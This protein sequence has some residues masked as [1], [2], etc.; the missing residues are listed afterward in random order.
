[1]ILFEERSDIELNLKKK[2]RGKEER[3][4]RE[5]GEMYARICL[6]ITLNQKDKICW[7][8]TLLNQQKCQPCVF[9]PNSY[10]PCGE[11]IPVWGLRGKP[12]A[13]LK[14]IEQHK[15]HRGREPHVF[16]WNCTQPSTTHQAH[17]LAQVQL[18]P[19]STA[20]G[21]SWN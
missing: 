3:Q 13:F 19:P 5:G 9:L 16:T 17:T 15:H 6:P 18:S 20:V 1:M 14:A 10:L 7:S 21:W 8:Q 11:V 4:K 2:R 12:K